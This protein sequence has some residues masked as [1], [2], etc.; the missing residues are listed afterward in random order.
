L[1]RR[2]RLLAETITLA[3]VAVALGVLSYAAQKFLLPQ[4]AATP[5]IAKSM[6]KAL[7]PLILHQVE[8]SQSVLSDAAVDKAFATIMARLHAALDQLAP[9]S[10]E[11]RIVVI[12]SP[13]INA[14]TL[15]GGIVCVDTGLMRN[16]DSAEQMAGVLGHELSHVAHRD[17]LALLARQV[18]AAALASVLTGGRGGEL[19]RTLAKTLVNFHYGREAEDRADAFSV[20]LLARADIDPSSFAHA[21]ERIKKSEPKDPRLLQWIDTHSPIDERIQRARQQAA[22]LSVPVRALGVNWSALV[23]GLPKTSP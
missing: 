3:A 13:E 1:T 19:A 8:Q 11:I 9:G 14:L 6:D 18:G 16:L 10:P 2:S 20:Q 21:L 22:K 4:R 15:P 23:R 7:G 17:P 5:E 12:D